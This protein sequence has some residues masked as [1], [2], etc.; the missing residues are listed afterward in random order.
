MAVFAAARASN[1]EKMASWVRRFRLFFFFGLFTFWSHLLRNEIAPAFC[2]SF[3]LGTLKRV[4]NSPP[5]N[6]EQKMDIVYRADPYTSR[7]KQATG[8]GFRPSHATT[9][10]VQ[11]DSYKKWFFPKFR[12][13]VCCET[14]PIFCVLRERR[15]YRNWSWSRYRVCFEEE[16]P[17]W[18]APFGEV[19]FQG[20]RRQCAGF[21]RGE[22]I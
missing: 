16:S 2:V 3:L 7:D 20:R 1:A 12:L 4:T 15:F 11:L 10:T 19:R 5:V 21:G 22:A 9:R 8:Y 6:M 17:A 18:H 14:E 13:C